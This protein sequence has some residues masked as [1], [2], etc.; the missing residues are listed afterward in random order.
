M[1]VQ[2]TRRGVAGEAER[3]VRSTTSSRVYV[4]LLLLIP[5]SVPALH[6][7]AVPVRNALHHTVFGLDV[8]A[9]RGTHGQ[10]QAFKGD[11]M[12]PWHPP[13]GLR[14]GLPFAVDDTWT[15]EQAWAVLEVLDDLRDR[16]WTHYGLA[17][18]EL[19]REQRVN[20]VSSESLEDFDPDLPF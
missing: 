13:S 6:T 3:V 18:Q 5:I 20:R 7:G 9:A 1:P 17:V 4:A 2:A 16:V 10:A 15:P 12:K 8:E 19:L 11:R 14:Q